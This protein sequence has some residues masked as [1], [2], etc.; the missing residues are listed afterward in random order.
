MKKRSEEEIDL[1]DIFIRNMTVSL[2][3]KMGYRVEDLPSI[4]K[5]YGEIVKIYEAQK[6]MYMP[7][8]SIK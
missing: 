1:K 7:I 3:G 5:R 2:T 4:R 6:G 8:D